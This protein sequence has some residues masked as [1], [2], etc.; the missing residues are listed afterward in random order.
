M[1]GS[2]WFLAERY[3]ME[4]KE[5]GSQDDYDLALLQLPLLYVRIRKQD[6]DSKIANEKSRMFLSFTAHTNMSGEMKASKENCDHLWRLFCEY[7]VPRMK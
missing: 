4:A 1:F 7:F 2:L 5:F 6:F 3:V